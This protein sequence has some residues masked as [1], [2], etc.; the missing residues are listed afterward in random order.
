[1]S[2]AN[3]QPLHLHLHFMQI[4]M[5][6]S[7]APFRQVLTKLFLFEPWQSQESLPGTVVPG[8]CPEIAPH[9]NCHNSQLT[10]RLEVILS[11]LESSHH[12]LRIAHGLILV[13]PSLRGWEAF[14][15][16]RA[17]AHTRIIWAFSPTVPQVPGVTPGGPLCPWCFGHSSWRG[18]RQ[19]IPN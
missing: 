12:E 11:I 4:L 16:P 17:L 8:R 2:D 9:S 7:L 19:L 5:D 13:H 1:M 6:N 14:P 15:T 3:K 18:A 10:P